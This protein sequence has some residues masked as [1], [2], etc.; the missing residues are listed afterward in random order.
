MDIGN[1]RWVKAMEWSGKS[2]FTTSPDVPFLVDGSE[3]GLLKQ[4][5]PLSF[6]KVAFSLSLI[7]AHVTYRSTSILKSYVVGCI[8]PVIIGS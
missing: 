4:H 8:G 5:G 1:S 3:A 6:L 2:E 7:C